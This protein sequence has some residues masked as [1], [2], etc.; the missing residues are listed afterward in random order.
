MKDM[1]NNT[2]TNGILAVLGII[3][4]LL[5]GWWLLSSNSDDDTSSTSNT[6]TEVVEQDNSEDDEVTDNTDNEEA[7]EGSNIVELA[8]A[9]P[10]LSTLVS[11]VVEA[12]LVDTLSGEGPFTVFAPTDDAFANTLEALD[13]TAEELLARDDLSDILTYHVVSGK[14]LSTDLTD[15]MVVNT[16]QGNTLTVGVHSDTG[17]TVTDSSGNVSTVTTADVDANN[18]VVHIVDTVVLP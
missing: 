5:I 13:I 2:S 1:K 12:N 4:A 17:V 11:A 16:V 15:G 14:V 8:Q 6:D 18:G 9:T 7:A 10:S 3:A